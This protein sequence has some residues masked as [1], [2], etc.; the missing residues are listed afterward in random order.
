MA[1]A[2]GKSGKSSFEYLQA[3]LGGGVTALDALETFL[4]VP[5]QLLDPWFPPPHPIAK[6]PPLSGRCPPHPPAL[7]PITSWHS[8][9]FISVVTVVT[10]LL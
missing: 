7:H 10:R 1:L 9:P 3:P 6:S 2:A 8:H 5:P 4:E